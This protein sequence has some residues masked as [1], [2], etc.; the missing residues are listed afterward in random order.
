MQQAELHV[1]LR[2]KDAVK[3]KTLRQ[4]GKVP[5]IFYSHNEDSLLF[6]VDEKELSRLLHHEHT[7]IDVVFPKAGTKKC[8]VREVQQDP[9]TSAY[10]H[11]DL[12]G[13]RMSEKVK[14]MIPVTITGNAIGV[15]EEGGILEQLIR[16]VEVEALPMDIPDHLQIDVAD[17][18][19]GDAVYVED[20]ETETVKI[21]ASP[22]QALVHVIQP[23]GAKGTA[24]EE[25]EEEEESDVVE[26]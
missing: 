18:H 17:L 16:E 7:I 4:T 9:V 20:V 1:E 26:E 22:R 3:P 5:G 2:G 19:L 21:M 23:R 10:I 13:I 8:I 15:K 25:G 14:M 11:I 12:M 6:S 24:L